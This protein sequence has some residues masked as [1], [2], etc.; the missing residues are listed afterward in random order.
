M[1][2]PL[3]VP[4]QTLRYWGRADLPEVYIPLAAPRSVQ[5]TLTD[6]DSGFARSHKGDI[7]WERNKGDISKLI[8]YWSR[9]EGAAKIGWG[10]ECD[11]CSCLAH[12]AKY[13]PPGQVK[14]FCAR[15]HKRATGKWPGPR[16]K[17]DHCPC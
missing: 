17:G 12:L 16:S 6:V 2:E 13:V 11:F 5:L 1:P 9:G 10:A 3:V 14:G 7:A 8:K 15:L 4:S